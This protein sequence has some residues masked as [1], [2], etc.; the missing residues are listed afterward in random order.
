MV[1]VWTLES[2]RLWRVFPERP[3][4]CVC[5]TLR[6]RDKPS[7][8]FADVAMGVHALPAP[9]AHGIV[10]EPPVEIASSR[11]PCGHELTERDGDTIVAAIG[12]TVQ[13]VT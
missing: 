12:L 9:H 8:A 6:V 4:Y 10:K 3:P 13:E 11:R 2:G 1:T 7:V 5:K